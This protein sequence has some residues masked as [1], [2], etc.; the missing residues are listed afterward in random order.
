MPRMI[1]AGHASCDLPFRPV[2][3]NV[4]NLDTVFVDRVEALTGGDALNVTVNLNKLGMG[5]DVRFVS[6]VGDDTFG[7]IIAERLHEY[8]VDTSG[9]IIKPEVSSIVTCILIDEDNERHFVFSGNSAR[10]ITVEDVLQ[11]FTADTEYLHIGS[12]MSLDKLEHDSM[13]RLF[14]EAKR[15]GIKTSFDVTYDQSNEWLPK[16]KPGLPYT[17][18]FFASYDEG[19]SLSGGLTKPEE[20][21]AF[22]KNEGVG[23]FVLKMGA[24]GVFATDYTQ[25]IRMPTYTNLQVVDTTGAGDSF[26]AAYMYGVLR[27]FSMEE[28]CLL[29]NMN[30]SLTVGS[31]GATT[32]SGTIDIFKAFLEKN[33][34]QTLN[35]DALIAKL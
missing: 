12:F 9:I 15:R 1:S 20:M 33:G 34:A 29:G 27:G 7:R 17:D 13:R 2:D 14:Q 11:S 25:V 16:I 22:F 6:V 31:I 19:V 24:E 28:C 8:G 10:N 30:G 3:K 18:I 5:Q 35:A 26:V 23:S 32:G 4:F 21:A